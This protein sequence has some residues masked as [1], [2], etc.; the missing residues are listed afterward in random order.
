MAYDDTKNSA[1]LQ[2]EVEQQRAQLEDRLDTIQERLSPGQLVDEVLAYAKGGGGEFFSGLQRNVTHNPL[3]VALLGVSLAWLIAKPVPTTAETDR[4]WDNSI[5]ARR[6]YGAH[7]PYE[8]YPV[9]IISG[10]SMQRVSH[11][12]D[13]HGAHV[14]EFIDD[15]GKKYR[16]ASDEAGRRA[17]HFMDETG[18]TYR[19]FTDQAGQQIQHFRDEAGN[20]LDEASGWASHTW[21]RAHDMVDGAREAVSHG[22]AKGR[23]QAEHA[24]QVVGEQFNSL[25]QTIMHQF[26]DQPLVAGALAFAAGAA[27]GSALP[28]TKQEDELMGETAD[29]LKSV[30][31]EQAEGLYQQGR[32]KAVELYENAATEAGRTY[33]RA[34]E[35][36]TGSTGHDTTDGNH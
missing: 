19:G 5:N 34:K 15:A 12:K 11:Q 27:F 6:G 4:Q 20:L 9:A 25:N 33:D 35:S 2:R 22:M 7:G 36:L 13:E 31:A 29:G 8:D 21:Q 32:D 10:T 26:R 17:G 28:H 16:A 30:A 23:A 1:Q 3:P 24:G 18:K 14:S